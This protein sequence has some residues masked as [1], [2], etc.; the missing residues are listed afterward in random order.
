MPLYP[1]LEPNIQLLEYRCI[2]FVEELLYGPVHKQQL[3]KHWEVN[4]RRHGRASFDRRASESL[5]LM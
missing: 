4:S 3:V 2:E 5:T 1:R